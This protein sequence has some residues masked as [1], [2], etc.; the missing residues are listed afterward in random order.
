MTKSVDKGQNRKNRL[1]ETLEVVRGNIPEQVKKSMS[2]YERA[3]FDIKSLQAASSIQVLRVLYGVF[4]KLEGVESSLSHIQD[5]LSSPLASS[6]D[7]TPSNG[8][9]ISQAAVDS[10]S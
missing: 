10:D 5:L 4:D 9:V 2:T 1:D 8:S 3:D 7:A 6:P